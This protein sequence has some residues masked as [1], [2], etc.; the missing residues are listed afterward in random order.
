VGLASDHLYPDTRV[1]TPAD[2]DDLWDVLAA[3]YMNIS[4]REPDEFRDF[5]QKF[6]DDH[7][8]LAA[9]PL[10]GHVV[11][12]P[13][14]GTIG[15]LRTH[16]HTV[17]GH[18]IGRNPPGPGR[19]TSRD[20]LQQL[21]FH[22]F[23]RAMLDVDCRWIAG[24]VNRGSR[25]M[26]HHVSFAA[27]RKSVAHTNPMRLV[28]VRCS[29]RAP[30]A[31]LVTV[32]PLRHGADEEIALL[33]AISRRGPAYCDSLDFIEDRLDLAASRTRFARAGLHRDRALF[34]AR[35]EG[36]PVVGA[37][38]E[39]VAP[40]LNLFG[41]HD[42]VRL[43]TLADDVPDD[44]RRDA[45]HALLRH[46]Q[47]WYA[48]HGRS[49]FAWIA[50]E[51]D[52]VHRTPVEAAAFPHHDNGVGDY[53]VVSKDN[54]PD[55]LEYIRE[56]TAVPSHMPRYGPSP[57]AAWRA[58]CVAVADTEGVAWLHARVRAAG[59]ELVDLLPRQ[60]EELAE[61]RDP[62]LAPEARPHPSDA[63]AAASWVYYPWRRRAVRVLGP[64]AYREV[65]L[66]RNRYKVTLAEQEALAQ[67]AVGV[68]GLSVGRTAAVTLAM[69]GVGG[70]LR[71]ADPDTLELSNLNRVA[72]SLAEVGMSKA[73]L[74][75]R[76]VAEIDPYLEVELFDE[77]VTADNLTT[78][79][80]GL[81]LL[82]EECDD[83]P[84]K[85]VLRE[86]ARRRRLPVLMDTSDRGLLDV[87]RFDHDAELGILHGRL[88]DAAPPATPEAAL[89]GVLRLLDADQLSPR[90][91]ASV[92]DH[93]AVLAGW[94]QC[95]DDVT[96]GG[97]VVTH[98]ARDILLG[99]GP[100]S[101]RYRVDVDAVLARP[102][103]A[104]PMAAPRPPSVVGDG[105]RL[106][107]DD[108]LWSAVTT[109]LRGVVLSHAPIPWRALPPASEDVELLRRV[110]ARSDVRA[111]LRDTGG[112]VRVG[113]ILAGSLGQPSYLRVTG[114]Q[115]LSLLDEDYPDLEAPQR[116]QL[117]VFRTLVR[118][119][120][121]GGPADAVVCTE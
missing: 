18:Q 1:A 44:V 61:V 98:V 93:K 19:P 14:E 72:S 86:E 88:D 50:E 70:R 29:P 101:G 53:W 25:W 57:D 104:P 82:V 102:E 45:R 36:V 37:I 34:V 9:A 84:L 97:A 40:G 30:T 96:L 116:A 17:M 69:G 55:F 114:G 79:L 108:A 111:A 13:G 6:I 51:G 4:G 71:L 32:M 115:G 73:V 112:G 103:V 16:G 3:K 2:L 92:L 105:P 8:R 64:T 77:G 49:R 91:A 67:R 107:V 24:F 31:R 35:H 5:R 27:T 47:D 20:V 89:A 63:E 120:V 65:R 121:G 43:I 75:A 78:F 110:V 46:A 15:F 58:E 28:E 38:F 60:L 85:V 119:R 10:L 41:L 68:V 94:P 56:M 95:A 66:S 59:G 81:D 106:A 100:G 83:V 12:W 48:S 76:A 117:E 11:L 42:S 33:R 22:G 90:S 54:I 109:F 118:A 21:Y 7:Q 23:E 80:D 62:A 87:E 113:A 99:R 74:A 26:R 52:V 39:A